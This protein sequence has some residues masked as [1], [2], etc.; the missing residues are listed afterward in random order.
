MPLFYGVYLS[1]LGGGGVVLDPA[2][3]M[4]STMVVGGSSSESAHFG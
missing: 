1:S 4:D 2:L 3:F